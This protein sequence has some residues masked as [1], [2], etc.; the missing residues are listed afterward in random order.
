MPLRA[1]GYGGGT[2]A[3]IIQAIRYAARLPN[4]TG[5]LPSEKADVINLSFGGTTNDQAFEDAIN[6]AYQEDIVIVA[7]AGNMGTSVPFYP[8]SFDNVISVSAVDIGAQIT[9]Y[10]NFGSTV[11]I[12]APGGSLQYDLNFDEYPDGVL[13]AS[14]LKIGIGSY[15][16]DLHVFSTGTSMAAP[17]V[18]G[19]AALI[20][21]AN[22]ELTA[23][24]I[25]SRIENH[26]VD[27]GASDR[28]DYYGHGLLNAYAAL[29]NGSG[30]SE[31]LFPFPKQFMLMGENPT[32]TL[33]LKNIGN[34]NAITIDD[35][36]PSM[37]GD[38]PVDLTETAGTAT[39]AGWDIEISIDTDTYAWLK[40]EETHVRMLTIDV[41]DLDNVED[42]QVYVLYNVIGFPTFVMIDIGTVYV[43]ANNIATGQKMRVPTT[44]NSLYR[45]RI[46]GLTTGSYIIGAST[47]HDNDGELFE[48]EDV[49]GYYNDQ[50]AVEIS[51]GDNIDGIDFNITVK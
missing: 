7:A 26:A 20:K 43:T 19:V 38:L 8:A 21:A 44:Y 29:K 23:N 22:P 48:P 40:D 9:Y 50:I 18:A 3:D 13:S 34:S 5:E 25:R 45:Y 28:D 32:K 24:G 2:T 17:H 4:G 12:A 47:D 14:S 39:A 11:D 49:F 51:S 37:D 41:N 46:S 35:I 33:T 31:V 15:Q 10:S 42:E 6:A 27:L 36:T 16:T 30:M 1:L